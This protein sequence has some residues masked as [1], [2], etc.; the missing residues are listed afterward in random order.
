MEPGCMHSPAPLIWAAWI[1][2]NGWVG[3]STASQYLAHLPWRHELKIQS[4][5]C[6]R[7]RSGGFEKVS[8]STLDITAMCHMGD[9]HLAG[10]ETGLLWCSHTLS[11]RYYCITL[12]WNNLPQ[13][14]C[15]HKQTHASSYTYLISLRE[16]IN[17]S[18]SITE[19]FW[20][21]SKV[22]LIKTLFI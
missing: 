16:A 17:L 4:C 19:Y 12:Q 15:A 9:I 5:L 18:S 8:V 14:M 10:V 3:A 13:L 1:N 11:L 7:K 2:G 21:K 22:S 20:N 6:S